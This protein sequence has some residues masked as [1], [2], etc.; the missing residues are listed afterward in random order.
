MSP[1]YDAIII[2]AGHNGLVAAATLAR[3]G[4]KVL[5]L[6]ARDHLGGMLGDAEFRVAPLPYALRPEIIKALQLDQKLLHGTRPL[7]T[8][9]FGADGQPLRITGGHVTGTDAITE[10]DYGAL[11]ARLGRQAKV[12]GA[13]ILETPP[14]LGKASLGEATA[15]ARM[16][17]KLRLLGKT[18]MRDLLRI[19]L[20]NVWDLLNDEIGDGPLAGA[21]AMDATLGGA[22]GP[23]SPGTVLTLLYRMAS[24]SSH[25]HGLRVMPE[26]GPDALVKALA[27]CVTAAGGGIRTGAP[28]E[29]ILVDGD[30]AAGVRLASGEEIAAPLVLSNASPKVTLLTLLGVAHLDGEFVRRC[31]TSASKG[32]VARLDFDIV[33]PPKLRGGGALTSGQRLVVAPTMQAIETAFNAAKYGNLPN[34]PVL[35]ATYDGA[36]RRLSVSAQF[37]P[38]DLTGG[39]TDDAKARLSTSVLT[40]LDDALPGIAPTV[41][42]T[43]VM[44]PVDIEVGYGAYGGHWH[45]GE[46]RVDQLL[47]LRP[48]DGAAQYRMPVA[49]LYL[50]GAGAHPGGDISG[51]AGFNAARAALRDGG[52]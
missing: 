1:R 51:A 17:L 49:G 14:G 35:E 36:A 26:G 37:A 6:E 30:R 33:E 16:A 9:T 15:L 20:S 32:M 25:G 24:Q 22:M 50:C 52:H 8:L 29:K 4:R 44:S 11:Y 10:H 34:R 23:R 3:K 45:H 41:H 2:G 27:D 48:F 46:L 21:L 5:V 39:W 31:R 12:L 7:E 40:V 43:R 38:H 18:E 13:M 28:V 47:M 42:G 19:V